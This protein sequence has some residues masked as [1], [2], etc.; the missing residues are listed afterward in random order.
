MHQITAF[1]L[2]NHQGNF[3]E[4]EHGFGRQS[5][6]DR[7]RIGDRGVVF[8]ACNKRH[9]GNRPG[10]VCGNIPVNEPHELLPAL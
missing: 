4:K 5:N 9:T 8:H 1:E 6:Q 10:R 2:F 3:H 7:R